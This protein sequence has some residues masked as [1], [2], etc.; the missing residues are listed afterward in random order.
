MRNLDQLRKS[1]NANNQQIAEWQ[2]ED[3][4]HPDDQIYQ[5]AIEKLRD[6]NGY[7]QKRIA[8]IVEL[9]ERSAEIARSGKICRR[10][11]A[12]APV[13]LS[14]YRPAK[15]SVSAREADQTRANLADPGRQ[16]SP[17]KNNPARY[18]NR[19]G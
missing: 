18:T 13:V 2:A 9:L 12:V 6:A 15:A 14:K 3:A 17:V 1:K 11:G 16:R 5:N 10:F 8:E 7:I 4:L 19:A